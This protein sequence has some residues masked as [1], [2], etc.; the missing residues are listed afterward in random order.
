MAEKSN[1]TTQKSRHPSL[2]RLLREV[3]SVTGFCSTSNCE[4]SDLCHPIS[5]HDDNTIKHSKVIT[6]N[7]EE[8]DVSDM[9]LRVQ[10]LQSHLPGG[11][12]SLDNK[13]LLSYVAPIYDC[14][15][16]IDAEDLLSLERVN[17]GGAQLGNGY[18]VHPI[19]DEVMPPKHGQN[20]GSCVRYL[21]IAE[22]AGSYSVGIFVF[23]PNATIP[24]HDHPNMCVLSRVLYGD[25]TKISLDLIRQPDYETAPQSRGSWLSNLMW[26]SSSSNRSM[27]YSKPNA[28]RALKTE[29]E[30]LCAPAV[31][32][33][34]PYEGNLHEFKAGPYGA[35]VLDVLLP[36]YDGYE[37]DCTFYSI[38]DDVGNSDPRACWIVPTGQPEDFHCL[39]GEYRNL[40][41]EEESD[42]PIDESA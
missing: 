22:L 20:G 12:D 13:T 24:L 38:E 2:V 15:T 14:L 39:S 23:P 33:L 29:T 25:V 31:T 8:S 11:M 34:Y 37:R 18:C 36:P 21:H 1:I 35:A 9:P 5:D 42:D 4:G 6:L 19:H 16:S 26:P 28:R 32:M 30:V 10:G 3:S 41:H 17:R 40:G 27:T 7:T